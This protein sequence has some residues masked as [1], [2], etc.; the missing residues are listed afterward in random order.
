M[1]CGTLRGRRLLLRW[2]QDQRIGTFIADLLG[3]TAGAA[4][5]LFN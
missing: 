5:V 2:A 3:I 4:L 1:W